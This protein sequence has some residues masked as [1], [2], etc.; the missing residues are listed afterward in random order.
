MSWYN[1]SGT[2]AQIT[3]A[4]DLYFHDALRIPN[5]PTQQAA[6]QH[7]Y[8]LNAA[9]AANVE[10]AGIAIAIGSGTNSV[11]PVTGGKA[12]GSQIAS[13]NAGA[14]Q[15]QQDILGQFNLGGWFLRVGEVLLGLVLIGVGIARIT[16]VQNAVSAVAKTKLIP[17]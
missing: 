1:F 14:Q 7:L 16:G 10:G 13:T 6:Q 9:Q 15:L 5:W 8:K 2:V 17:V 12:A 3:G 11:N 4:E